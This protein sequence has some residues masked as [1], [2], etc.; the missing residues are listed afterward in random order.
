MQHQAQETAIIGALLR[1]ANDHFTRAGVRVQT[2]VSGDHAQARYLVPMR[3]GRLM[4]FEASHP[5]SQV[6]V[7][8]SRRA[9]R[10]AKR[11]ARR[12]RIK[13]KLKHAV[14]KV[15]H[16]AKKVARSKAFRKLAKVGK[17]ALKLVPGGNYVRM[18]I[19]AARKAA[20]L[21][22]RVVRR[23]KHAVH[24]VKHA[25]HRVKH[26]VHAAPHQ[27]VKR[28]ALAVRAAVPALAT[29][30]AALPLGIRVTTPGGRKAIV[31][32]VE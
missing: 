22:K 20:H 21:A 9:R 7:G 11:H 12:A 25:V 18:G 6:E 14:H 27:G 1:E 13:R 15:K 2:R 28:H 10:K 5:L 24:R 19:K 3:D 29:S 8:R 23:V 31:T 26:A 17:F 4:A 16:F 30:A 32:F